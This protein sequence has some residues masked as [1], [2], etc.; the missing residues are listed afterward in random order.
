MADEHNEQEAA[1]AA[2]KKSKKKLFFIILILTFLIAG[3][4][5]GFFYWRHRSAQKQELAA[6]AQA[7]KQEKH[8]GGE[9]PEVAEV[10]ELLPFIVNLADREEPKYLRM[11]VSLGISEGAEKP[12]PLFTTKVRNAILAVVTTKTA[13]QVLTVEGK[14]E[15]R[16]EMLEAAKSCVNKPEV[17]AIYITDFIVQM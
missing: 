16:K 17:R 1:E 4:T 15:L 14:A 8:A 3:G 12:D 10:I 11:T 6:K 5:G 2:P 13:D 7:E 9:E